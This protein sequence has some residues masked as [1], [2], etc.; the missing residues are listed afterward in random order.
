MQNNTVSIDTSTQPVTI[1]Y[2]PTFNVAISFIDNHLINGRREKT[3]IKVADG[4]SVTYGQ[5]AENVGRAGNGLLDL[6]ITPG[7]RVLMMIKDCP[8]FYYLF[9]GAKI[10]RAH[11]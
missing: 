11:V 8:V 2:A 6:G 1:T 4:E 5:L 3:A 9:W 7:N 10:G